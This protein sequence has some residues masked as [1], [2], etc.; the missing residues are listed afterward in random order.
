VLEYACPVW[1]P[2]TAKNIN[3]L[4]SVQRKAAHWASNSRWIPSSYCWSKS[5][6]DCLQELNW[7]S[8]QIRHNYYS[9]CYVHDS[10]HHRNSLPFSEHFQLST[11]SHTLTIQPVTSSINSFHYSFFVNSPFLWNTMPYTILQIKK[12]TLFHAALCNFLF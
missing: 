2:Y 8:I 10:L 11:R 9:V 4:E 1:H 6:D 12:S 7:P 3:V 5:S